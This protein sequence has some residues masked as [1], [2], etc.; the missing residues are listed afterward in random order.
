[1]LEAAMAHTAT[2]TRA[3]RLPARSVPPYNTGK[4]AIG[5]AHVHTQRPHHDADALRLQD[6]LLFD[7]VRE[8][9]MQ[10]ELR[11]EARVTVFCSVALVAVMGLLVTGV[12]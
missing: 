4:V 1:M 5:I 12:L 8:A 9:A 7:P 6:A 2:H 11:A 3:P 10:R